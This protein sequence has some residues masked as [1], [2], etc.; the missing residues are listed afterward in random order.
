MRL[1][2]LL[3][4]GAVLAVASLATGAQAGPTLDA[5]KE[6]G[7]L[8]CGVS[9]GL[10]G[11]SLADAQGN[12]TGLDVDYCRAM[13]AALFGD[14]TAVE[15]VPLSAQ[16]RFT[17][18]Q[19]GEVDI[20][21]R[22]TT[23]TLTRD[24][25]LGLV[26]AGVT[27]FDGQGFMVPADLGVQSALE[28]DGA[29]VCVQPGTT[30][31]LNLADY[32]RA[33]SMEFTGV[34]IESFEQSLETFFSGRCQVYTTDK[35]GLAAIIANDAPDP[36]AYIILPETISKEP[37]GP[38]VRRGDD[39]FFTIAKWVV[40]GLIEAEEAGVNSGN[41]EEMKSSENP[42]VQRLLGTSDAMGDLL[43][44]PADWAVQMISQVGNYGE[45][46]DR[47]VGPDTPL[48]LE[49]GQNDLWTRGGLMYA[50]PV[51]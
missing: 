39:E 23:W 50:M 38:V 29:E 21:S 51:R 32:F 14:S 20:L 19:S 28:L 18:L 46:F 7:E 8:R 34:V 47:N 9:T 6:R 5:I 12:W 22:N 3:A 36:D 30:T 27:F 48:R 45:I 41:V 10:A 13:A 40:Y 37:L 49:R 33:N 43:G 25:S 2:Q 35:S 31:E 42:T 4:G 26:F 1:S 44:L 16:Q 24:A 15:F 17:A 11:F